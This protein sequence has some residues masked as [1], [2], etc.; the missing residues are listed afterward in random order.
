MV[1]TKQTRRKTDQQGNP[2]PE[3]EPSTPA[4]P[5]EPKEKKGILN[6]AEARAYQ[7]RMN[8]LVREF[9]T[10]VCNRQPDPNQYSMLLADI[11]AH[12][13]TAVPAMEAADVETVVESIQDVTCKMLRAA[14]GTI[15][16][17][18]VVE[19]TEPDVLEPEAVLRSKE[20]GRT[21]T[22]EARDTITEIFNHMA[23]ARQAEGLGFN[24]LAVLAQMVN[25]KQFMTV[26][27]LA[28][29]PPYTV[30]VNV[31][32]ESGAPAAEVPTTSKPTT[33]LQRIRREILPDP[34]HKKIKKIGKNHPTR[35]LAAV[36]AYKITKRLWESTAMTHEAKRYDVLYNS[37][38]T[39]ITAAK[40]EGRGTGIEPGTKRKTPP[41]D[42]DDDDEEDEEERQARTAPAEPRQQPPR[43]AKR[44]RTEP[45]AAEG[46][47]PPEEEPQDPEDLPEPPV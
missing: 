41:D 9:C 39:A 12:C 21:M 31:A 1:K 5:P 37:L 6:L 15:E 3:G 19:F 20:L 25:A 38:N 29:T 47:A 11:K 14:P 43:S 35:V 44:P 4:A 33:R 32:G 24:R 10:V 26:A 8:E 42:D 28:A 30:T 36:A 22:R 7:E 13:M 18:D 40:Y 45:S 46:K 34:N 17:Q 23:E 2:L 16:G 27:R